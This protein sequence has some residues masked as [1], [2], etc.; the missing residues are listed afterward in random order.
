VLFAR[1]APGIVIG[2]MQINFRLPDPLPAGSAFAFT[3]W[4]GGVR[5]PQSLIAV[6]PAGS[7]RSSV[8][9][10]DPVSAV[11]HDAFHRRLAVLQFQP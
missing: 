3:V 9:N 1:A 11:H 5:S 6:A 8:R 4:V 10:R 2:V 7:R